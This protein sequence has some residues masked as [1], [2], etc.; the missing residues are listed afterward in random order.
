MSGAGMPSYSLGRVLSKD[1]VREG[2]GVKDAGI[3]QL[4]EQPFCT[5]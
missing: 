3:A 2:E 4:A 5:R 1:E